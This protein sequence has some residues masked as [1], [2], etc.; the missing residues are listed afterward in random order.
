MFYFEIFIYSKQ[1]WACFK[2]KPL[3]LFLVSKG[4]RTAEVVKH[5]I[6][7]SFTFHKVYLLHF[8]ICT[9]KDI[10]KMK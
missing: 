7:D 8:W 1:G 2:K 4:K 10:Y 5:H 6:S 9:L 3:L